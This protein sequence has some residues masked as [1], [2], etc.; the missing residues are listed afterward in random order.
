MVTKTLARVEVRETSLE[1]LAHSM[2]IPIR[3]LPW[4]GSR[5]QGADSGLGGV[6]SWLCPA[7]GN[8]LKRRPEVLDGMICV[9]KGKCGFHDGYRIHTH[10]QEVEVK[11]AGNRAILVAI[12][13]CGG[14]I[15]HHLLGM[16]NTAPY[17]V[18][19][20][21][22]VQTVDA[23]FQW[24]IPKKVK[25]AVIQGLDVKRQGDWFFIPHSRD[26]NLNKWDDF[27]HYGLYKRNHLYRNHPLV[28]NGALTRHRASFVVY[29]S[30]LGLPCEAPI[31]KGKVRAPDHE[32]LN[33][34]NQWHLGIRN[35]SHPW[36]NTQ[37]RNQGDD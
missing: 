21:S 29:N 2:G 10:K 5:R 27:L 4:W 11:D 23:A 32:M 16:D 7:A 22:R 31:V 19:V 28:Y 3:I 20:S 8:G 18:Q 13:S 25:E 35:R 37:A 36:R 17:V 9:W 6:K 24:L 26:P 34:G 15:S 33:L 1:E 30:I 12:R 14:V